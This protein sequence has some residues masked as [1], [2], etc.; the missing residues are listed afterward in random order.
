MTAPALWTAAEAAAATNGQVSQDW[1]AQGVSIDSRSL[2]A[3]DLF[4]ALKGPNFDGHNFL[5]AAFDKGAVAALVESQSANQLDHAPLLIVDDALEAL[6]GLG[7]AARMRAQARIVAVTGS[8]GKTSVKEAIK[9]CLE[10]QGSVHAATGSFNNHFGLPLTLARLPRTAQYAVLEIGMNH[11]GEIEPLVRLARPHVAV[12]TTI[13]AV[14]LENFKDMTG[15]ADAKAEILLGLEPDGVAIFNR[16]NPYFDYLLRRAHEAGVATVLSFGTHP[17]ADLRA[18][19]IEARPDGVRV[20]ADILGRRIDYRVGVGG[21]PWGLNSLATLGAVQALGGDVM[22]AAQRLADLTPAYGRGARQQVMAS[23]RRF[24]VIDD[25]YNASPVSVRAAL[26]SLALGDKKGR[27]LAVLGDMLE[28]GPQAATLHADLADEIAAAGVD[29]VFAAGPL[30]KSLYDALRP[31]LRGAWAVNSNDLASAVIN[32]VHDGDE[33][34][35]KGSRGMK[36]DIIVK[37]LLD[38]GDVETAKKTA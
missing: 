12:I 20:S 22:R 9:F 35:V 13:E 7:R 2:I 24:T 36:T 34:L 1:Q 38:L 15:I 30:M 3:G 25:S 27:R 37:A 8:V 28:L 5:S 33:I 26:R 11:A 17:A 31:A 23:G 21:V 6:R 4:I 29:A 16:D 14:H 10:D 32:A 18:L 19:E